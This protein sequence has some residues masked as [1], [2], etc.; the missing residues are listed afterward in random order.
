MERGEVHRKI[1]A[2]VFDVGGVLEL[3][4]KKRQ[5]IGIIH[6][7]GIHESMA[8][9]LGLS[10]DQYYD[11]IDSIYAKSMEGQVSK[12]ILLGTLSVNLNVSKKK[13]ESMFINAYRK[14]Y[15][16]NSELFSIAKRLKKEGY[17]IGIL[18]DQWHLSKDALLVKKDYNIFDTKVV[19]CDVGIRKPNPE[20][21]ELLLKRLKLEPEEVLFI[22]N[23][24]W[25]IVPA[26]K[27]G[28]KTILFTTNKKLKEQLKPF[29]I[30]VK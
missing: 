6:V 1:K 2:V 12:S 21:Y 18:S 25:N 7:S 26:N 17:K 20:I 30:E 9:K 15:K 3:G 29:G 28:I 11:S 13:L 27:M 5:N 22:D 23:Q 14:V 19:S 8:K 10:M 24:E 16:K 4:G